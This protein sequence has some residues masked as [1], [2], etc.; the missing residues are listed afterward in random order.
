MFHLHRDCHWVWLFYEKFIICGPLWTAVDRCGPLWTAVDHCGPLWTAVDC[1]GPLRT[2]VDHSG[3]LWP[4]WPYKTMSTVQMFHLH[5]DCHWVWSCY[6]KFMI[7]GP[8]WTTLDHSGPLWTTLDL[9]DHKRPILPFK[10]F[11][12]IRNVIEC[13][14][15]MRSSWFLDRCGPIWTILYQFDHIIPF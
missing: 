12:C 14:C 13:G 8:L 11:I 7:C 1:C 6:K 3:P 2:A 15:V 10:C 9:S 4:L 5:R